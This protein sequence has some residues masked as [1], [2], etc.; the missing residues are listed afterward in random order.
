MVFCATHNHSCATLLT[1]PNFSVL[2]TTTLVCGRRVQ[3]RILTLLVISDGL[4]ARAGMLSSGRDRFMPWRTV[5]GEEVTAL[6][7]TLSACGIDADP[8][9]LLGRF[10]AAQD[11]W[12]REDTPIIYG[13]GSKHF[14]GRR[15]GATSW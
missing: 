7:C 13:K 2:P 3:A 5:A 4:Q 12:T 11:P 14:D 15:I 1:K 10:P 9:R 8:G 6:G